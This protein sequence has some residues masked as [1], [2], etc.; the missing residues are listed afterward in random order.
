MSGI[1]SLYLPSATISLQASHPL[2]SSQA[3]WAMFAFSH[4]FW[5]GEDFLSSPTLFLGDRADRSFMIDCW[6]E[7]RKCESRNAYCL[8]RHVPRRTLKKN[9]HGSL[10]NVPCA[11][12]TF[13][14]NL[15]IPSHLSRCWCR[16][17]FVRHR[18]ISRGR[19]LDASRCW[20][21]GHTL[22][23]KMSQA[24]CTC[25]ATGINDFMSLNC[26][27]RKLSPRTQKKLTSLLFHWGIRPN[28]AFASRH[29]PIHITIEPQLNN[30][31]ARELT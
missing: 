2:A 16:G 23:P 15:S 5:T 12:S 6:D 28:N 14:A 1:C 10:L 13:K 21:L 27:T 19:R 3:S 11:S 29:L 22:W 8:T 31:Q 7:M 20:E 26:R 30:N 24:T 25:I 18:G 17:P 4:A 9:G